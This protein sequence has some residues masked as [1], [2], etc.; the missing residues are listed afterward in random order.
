MPDIVPPVLLALECV[1][2]QIDAL[3]L[4]GVEHDPSFRKGV[5]PRQEDGT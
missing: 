5:P 2:D 4:N 1:R 3:E